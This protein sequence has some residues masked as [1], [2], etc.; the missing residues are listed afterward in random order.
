MLEWPTNFHRFSDM[1]LISKCQRSRTEL[2]TKKKTYNLWLPGQ[3]PERWQE[4]AQAAR[5]RPALLDGRQ[6]VRRSSLSRTLTPADFSEDEMT[7]DEATVD[8]ESVEKVRERERE[9]E[10]GRRV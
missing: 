7:D 6:Q 10:R 4:H 2:E 5:Q 8:A 9:R 1:N 3:W